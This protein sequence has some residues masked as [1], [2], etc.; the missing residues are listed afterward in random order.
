MYILSNCKGAPLTSTEITRSPDFLEGSK[1]N[2]MPL[3]W[4]NLPSWAVIDNHVSQLID[5]SLNTINKCN[6]WILWNAI[7]ESLPQLF[8]SNFDFHNLILN[9]EEGWEE[10]DA[11]WEVSVHTWERKDGK[12]VP[13]SERTWSVSGI[14]SNNQS[15]VVQ[16]RD[17]IKSEYLMVPLLSKTTSQL[18][19]FL[20][21]S[22][23]KL[24]MFDSWTYSQYWQANENNSS[25]Y[26]SS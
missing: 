22:V 15:L 14:G 6:T 1:V 18:N 4:G 13:H 12:Q 2:L 7:L 16:H 24:P 9:G 21:T 25:T 19:S 20:I 8:S 26:S 23:M 10:D 17:V 5:E 11:R 3:T